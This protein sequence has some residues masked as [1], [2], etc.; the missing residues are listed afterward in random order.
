MDRLS[1]SSSFV[2]D[3]ICP[4]VLEE[5]KTK[6]GSGKAGT[7]CVDSPGVHPDDQHHV[8]YGASGPHA[9]GQDAAEQQG[10]TRPSS[11]RLYQP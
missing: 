2:R 7:A 5:E 10:G 6:R 3:K 4:K 9:G 11:F 1:W 8:P